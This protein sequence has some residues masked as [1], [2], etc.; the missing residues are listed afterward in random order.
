[1][2]PSVPPSVALGRAFLG[3]SFHEAPLYITI[4]EALGINAALTVTTTAGLRKYPA[5]MLFGEID[6]VTNFKLTPPFLEITVKNPLRG[7]MDGEG[8]EGLDAAKSL[9][10]RKYH[11]EP[12]I[13]LEKLTENDETSTIQFYGRIKGLFRGTP[14]TDCADLVGRW[15]PNGSV[16][17]TRHEKLLS[18]L[19][20]K[21]KTFGNYLDS[22]PGCFL[23]INDALLD[24]YQD[25]L[26]R[27]NKK[28]ITTLDAAETS[29]YSHK[30][31]LTTLLAMMEQHKAWCGEHK[32]KF[33][34]FTALTELPVDILLRSALEHIPDAMR[35]RLGADTIY[36]IHSQNEDKSV[37]KFFELLKTTQGQQSATKYS[38][39]ATLHEDTLQSQRS[40]SPPYTNPHSRHEQPIPPQSVGQFN[41]PPLTELTAAL[42][43]LR[44]E[45]R[46]EAKWDCDNTL[47][48]MKEMIR[49]N[50]SPPT[51]S[52]PCFNWEK[53]D[54]KFG[55]RCSF[56]HVG[57]KH[58]QSSPNSR[59][60]SKSSSRDSYP[61]RRARSRSP[62][63][64][65][66][67]HRDQ[68]DAR[69]RRRDEPDTHPQHLVVRR[70]CEWCGFFEERKH[71]DRCSKKGPWC[72]VCGKNS[73]L[74][75]GCLK[76]PSLP[77]THARMWC[78][79]CATEEHAIG[80]CPHRQR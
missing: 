22:F 34:V 75:A 47:N 66:R 72:N 17:G 30:S 42:G 71:F 55:D 60:N 15:Y 62:I 67:K 43:N 29:Y 31:T 49:N 27:P 16:G 21:L 3:K 10:L 56:S 68:P 20:T 4:H 50:R 8:K 37:E 46:N 12:F 73:H 7:G 38:N 39:L 52:R 58:R 14:W 28:K 24:K 80:R 18:I 2:A 54:C 25:A 41:T 45:L 44:D 70:L 32:T 76:K 13:H 69:K 23:T 74:A 1:V 65:E 63:R 11:R 57:P 36:T 35:N 53:G 48:V 77:P 59:S 51:T 79:I 9:K 78:S 26:K 5:T 6:G 19:G 40:S 64:R 33:R 61:T